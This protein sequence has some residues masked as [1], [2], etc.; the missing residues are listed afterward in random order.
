[1]V[2]LG[3]IRQCVRMRFTFT[4]PYLGTARSRS[5]VF[6]VCRYSGGSS[7]S[8]WIC[9]RPAFRSFLSR[10]RRVRMSF[11]RASA[12]MRWV[13]ER[14]GARPTEEVLARV[15]GA[16]GIPRR[17]YTQIRGDLGP[18]ANFRA[19]SPAPQLE[20]YDALHSLTVCGS[21]AGISPQ[22]ARTARSL[23]GFR[24]GDRRWLR[25]RH[26]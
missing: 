13:S 4:R 14:S 5:K 17:S 10:A 2:L 24:P 1:M 15:S 20:V 9:T 22:F 3:E 19:N 23:Q 21:F 26:P 12:S 8:P 25:L 16:T 6:A 7:S 18:T 11:A